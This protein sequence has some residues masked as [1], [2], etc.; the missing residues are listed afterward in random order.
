MDYIKVAISAEAATTE[1]LM[2]LLAERD[3]DTFEETAEGLAAYMPAPKF[4]EQEREHLE[5][6]SQV[7]QFSFVAEF[8]PARNW[9]E[10]W[11]SNFKPI[12]IGQFCGVRAS[13]H[14]PMSGLKHELVIDPKMAFGTGHHETTAMMIEAME[15]IPFEGAS[16]LDFGCGTG[17]LA[18][19]ASR[20]G[21]R[22]VEAIDIETE[23]CLNT[24][25]NAQV[26]GVAAIQVMQGS[27]EA[28]ESRQYDVILANINRNVI[29]SNL[30][31]LHHK[32]PPATGIL[33]LSG[34]VLEDEPIML[35]AMEATGFET[36][37]VFRKNNWLAIKACKRIG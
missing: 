26:N 3:Y 23:S 32:L 18:I 11:E 33:L 10:E 34:F 17:I 7:Y 25:T 35:S 6:L 37:Q 4:S 1:I 24:K 20:L 31:E 14:S 2:A 9:N 12:Q 27:L 5:A 16:V 22:M 15:G 13:F 19:L 36:K 8:L 30:D 28:V 21:A 29:L